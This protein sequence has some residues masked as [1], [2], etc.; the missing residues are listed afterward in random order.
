MLLASTETY[1]G[2]G[3]WTAGDNLNQARRLLGAAAAGGMVCAIGGYNALNGGTDCDADSGLCSAN[4]CLQL[5][6]PSISR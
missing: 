4:E 3:P 1:S 6:P 5:A 2:N